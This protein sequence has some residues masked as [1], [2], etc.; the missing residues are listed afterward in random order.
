M[1]DDTKRARVEDDD[2]FSWLCSGEESGDERSDDG[3]TVS[4]SYP[5]YLRMAYVY[6]IAI[7]LVHVLQFK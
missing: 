7:M 5:V 6:Y 1:A 2:S 3:S 4:G